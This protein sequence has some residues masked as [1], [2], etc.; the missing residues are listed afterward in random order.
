[1]AII[2]SHPGLMNKN[3]RL[4]IAKVNDSTKKTKRLF[5]RKLF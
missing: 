3:V 4:L 1:M 5:E 2:V